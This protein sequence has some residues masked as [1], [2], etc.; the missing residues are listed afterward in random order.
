MFR[1]FSRISACA[2]LAACLF[3]S[4]TARAQDL[5][6]T[7]PS[8]NDV[9][10]KVSA[11]AGK[12]NPTYSMIVAMTLGQSAAFG[13]DATKPI[14]ICVDPDAEK[15]FSVSGFI[16]VKSQKMFDT[17][18]E[19]LKEKGLANL[20]VESKDGYSVLLYNKESAGDLPNFDAPKMLNFKMNPGVLLSVIDQQ[21]AAAELTEDEDLKETKKVNLERMKR[22]LKQLEEVSF[23]LDASDVGDLALSFGAKPVEGTDIA[24]NYANSEK[25]TQSVLGGFFDKKAP[26]TA[27]F[28]GTFDENNRKDL[29][30]FVTSSAKIPQELADVVLKAL[31]VK[32]FDFACSFYPNKEGVYGVLAMGIANGDKIN[33]AIEKAIEKIDADDMIQGKANAGTIGKSITVHEFTIKNDGENKNFAVAVHQKYL[34]FALAPAGST[35]VDY[36][37]S[38]FK[39]KGLKAAPVKKNA[40]L[41]FDVGLLSSLAGLIGLKD[42]ADLSGEVNYVGDF[43]N[44]GFN[45]T[46]KIDGGL[47]ETIGKVIAVKTAISDDDDDDDLFGDDDDDD[48]TTEAIGAPEDE[49]ENE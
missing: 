8:L 44:G 40:Q 19:A 10:T 29:A 13:I 48:D 34:F 23:A 46:L 43:S 37:K 2:A 39:E 5:T 15:G 7:I 30:E 21:I 41:R 47:L 38:V 36:L 28:L 4:S 27:Q 24:N 3:L 26:F 32:K 33:T 31:D 20:N 25:L 16:P 45:G 42:D 9:Q 1:I 18:I 6:V 35:A 17:Q 49:E 22:N 12:I 14:A 11:V